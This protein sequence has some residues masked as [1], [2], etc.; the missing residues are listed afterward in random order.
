MEGSDALG[1]VNMRVSARHEHQSC[2]TP[3]KYMYLLAG[4]LTHAPA[5]RLDSDSTHDTF[6]HTAY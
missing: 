5:Y 1:D 6:G 2:V 3:K 4:I